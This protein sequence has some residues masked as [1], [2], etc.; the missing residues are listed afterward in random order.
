[1]NFKL[2]KK[3]IFEFVEFSNFSIEFVEISINNTS[4]CFNWLKIVKKKLNLKDKKRIIDRKCWWYLRP[5][6]LTFNWMY[7]SIELTLI[8]KFHWLCAAFFLFIA[9]QIPI[10]FNNNSKQ[11]VTLCCSKYQIFF[12]NQRTQQK[13]KKKK[14][15]SKIQSNGNNHTRIWWKNFSCSV[16]FFFWSYFFNF[17]SYPIRSPSL[18]PKYH[19]YLYIVNNRKCSSTASCSSPSLHPSMICPYSLVS[20]HFDFCPFNSNRNT[21]GKHARGYVDRRFFLRFFLN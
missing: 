12:W 1:L 4:I 3:T 6:T 18:P 11:F 7:N 19:C 20:L 8:N 16:F 14:I 9:F 13:K 10:G 21:N 17:N 15:N 5:N 2:K